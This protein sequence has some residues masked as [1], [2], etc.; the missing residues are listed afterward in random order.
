MSQ[1][2]T[3]ITHINGVKIQNE[4]AK[5]CI[6]AEKPVL[7]TELYKGKNPAVNGE[8]YMLTLFGPLWHVCKLFHNEPTMNEILWYAK[9]T[10][11]YNI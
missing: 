7:R 6:T 1:N 11:T 9:D 8:Y 5:V 10:L 3:P 2:K 4:V